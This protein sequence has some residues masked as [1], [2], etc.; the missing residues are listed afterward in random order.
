MAIAGCQSISGSGDDESPTATTTP[1]Q[2]PTETPTQTPTE[3]PTELEAT[4]TTA[5]TEDASATVV[6]GDLEGAEIELSVV[7]CNRALASAS[8]GSIDTELAVSFHYTTKAEEYWETPVFRVRTDDT[9]V[10]DHKD[11]QGTMTARL[12]R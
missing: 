9:L 3:T 8:L 2:T 12:G 4:W 1:T 11:D 6:N 5:S 10:Y 7:K